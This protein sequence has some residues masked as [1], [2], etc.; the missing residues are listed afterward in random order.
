MDSFQFSAPTRVYYGENVTDKAL[1][2]ELSSVGNTVMLAY[3]KGSIKRNGLYDRIM[4]ILHE[5]GKRVVEFSGI[6]PN[7]TLAKVREGADLVRREGVDFV[8]AAGGGSV[9]DCVKVFCTQ[10]LLDEDIWSKECDRKEFPSKAVP[11]GVVVTVSGTGSEQNN[12][13]VITNEDLKIKRSL[14]STL[15]SFSILDPVLTASVPMK[16]V[17]SGAYDSLS[18]CMEE[19]FGKPSASFI[20]DELNEAVQKN[21]I[22]NMRA[23]LS[24]PKDMSARGELM[25]DSALAENNLLKLAKQTDFQCHQIEHQLGAYTDCVHGQG[26][27]AIHPTLYRHLLT[28]NAGKFARWAEEVWGIDRY[29]ESENELSD[30]EMGALAIDSLE[31]FTEE[32]GLPTHLKD[33]GVGYDREIL[34]RVADS[35]FIMPGCARQLDPDEIYQILLEAE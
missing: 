3:G 17:M 33:L 8:L 6:M 34:R 25:W 27:A 16:Q 26:L 2:K 5:L 15:P 20:T 32:V 11:Y 29:D 28:D 18:H 24:D 23:V 13:G 7:P 4:S 9:S 35:A 31:E 21:I 22:R 1:R 19:Y 12:G 10:A 14:F 30:L